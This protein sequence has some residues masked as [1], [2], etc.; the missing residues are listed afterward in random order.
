MGKQIADLLV[1]ANKVLAPGYSLLCLTDTERALPV[2]KPG[3]FAQVRAGADGVPLLRRPISINFVD[4]TRNE[5]QILVHNVGKGTAKICAVK[6]GERLNVLFPLGNGFTMD[7][8]NAPQKKV[9][10]VGGGVGTAPLL[11]LGK[12]LRE[13]GD[14]PT[15]LLGGK[16]ERDLMQLSEFEKFGRVFV[17][18]EDGSAGE[19]GF[20]TQHS[21]LKSE[22]FDRVS[23][24]GPKPMMIAVARYAA[25]ADIPCEVSLENLMACGMG[26]CLCCVEQ[27]VNGNN[28]CVCTE[29]PVFNIKKL[30]WLN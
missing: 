24:C 28:V 29:G 23:T 11:Y 3:Q 1:T 13:R 16:R 4:E 14:E 27:D 2:I 7:A 17:T 6:E 12:K 18:T 21:L 22:T 26:A 19:R 15:F 20:V 5:L 8:S 9:L 25:Q 10:L 30:K